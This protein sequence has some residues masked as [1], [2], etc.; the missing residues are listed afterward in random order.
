MKKRIELGKK[1]QRCNRV[2]QDKI[3]KNILENGCKEEYCSLCPLY[4]EEHECT[5]PRTTI[6]NT[7]KDIDNFLFSETCNYYLRIDK[8]DI[9]ELRYNV[10]DETDENYCD[11]V[12]SFFNNVFDTYNFNLIFWDDN[13]NVVKDIKIVDYYDKKL[14]GLEYENSL[15]AVDNRENITIINQDKFKK[16][17]KNMFDYYLNNFFFDNEVNQNKMVK[18]KDNLEYDKKLNIKNNQIIEEKIL[19]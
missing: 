2:V 14:I 7:L 15:V 12:Y 9:C 3:I 13:N 19:T 1:F 5:F 6:K 18:I 8:N 17:Y 4:T 16:M 10:I 11:Y